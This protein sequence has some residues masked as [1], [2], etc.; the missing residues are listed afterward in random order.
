MKSEG[1]FLT[2]WPL[3]IN[4]KLVILCAILVHLFICLSVKYLKDGS[5]L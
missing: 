4:I 2:A 1:Y 3:H 5:Y